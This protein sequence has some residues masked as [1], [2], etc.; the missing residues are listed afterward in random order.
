MA[1]QETETEFVPYLNQMADQ[2]TETEFVPYESVRLIT[3]DNH[4]HEW[5][6]NKAIITGIPGTEVKYK[7]SAD[8]EKTASRGITTLAYALECDCEDGIPLNMELKYAEQIIRYYAHI[9]ENP[10]ESREERIKW[11]NIK[12]AK[13][14]IEDICKLISHAHY[15]GAEMLMADVIEEKIASRMKNSTPEQSRAFLKINDDGFT[16]KERREA[17]KKLEF[18]YNDPSDLAAMMEYRKTHPLPEEKEPEEQA[19]HSQMADVD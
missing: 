15:L 6:V 11:L 12:L 3:S 19:E 16:D 1:N 14:E 7:I 2:E 13:T 5:N 17:Y 4:D 8:V 18:E 9:Y 10:F